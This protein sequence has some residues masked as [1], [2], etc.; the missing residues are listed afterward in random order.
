R[1][2]VLGSHERCVMSTRIA[3]VPS[4][5][6]TFGKMWFLLLALPSG[7]A[8]AAFEAGDDSAGL[9]AYIAQGTSMTD[10]HVAPGLDSGSAVESGIATAC[11]RARNG[12]APGFTREVCVPGATFTM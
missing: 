5:R 12:D 8:G 7:C 6:A 4:M 3:L 11:G 2:G 10:D 9:D 1:E